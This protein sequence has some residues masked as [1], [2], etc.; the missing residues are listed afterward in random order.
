MET[1]MGRRVFV[2]SVVAA[3]PLVASTRGKL[4]AQSSSATHI[5][6]DNTI[7]N[8]V[9][10]HINRQLATNYN[11]MRRDPRGEHLRAF[12]AQLRTLTVYSRQNHFDDSIRSGVAALVAKEGRYHVLYLEP[13]RDRMRSELRAFGVQPDERLLNTAVSL[14]YTARQAALDS[15]LRSGLTERWERLAT[16]LERLAPEVDRRI[17]GVVR[18]SR[19]DAAYWEGYCTQLWGEFSEVMFLTGLICAAA[20]IPIIGIAIAP[21]CFAHQLAAMILGFTYGVYCWNVV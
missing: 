21:L 12:A 4:F 7:A 18:V 6:P 19:Q 17:S 5:H 13:D 9:L 20:L 11:A 14:D 2:G 8:P 3:L 16:M 1:G 15:L 10:E